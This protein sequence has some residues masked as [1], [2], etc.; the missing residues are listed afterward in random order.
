[1]PS[2]GMCCHMGVVRA[3]VS[4]ERAPSIFRVERIRK[5]GTTSPVN[6]PINRYWKL[7]DLPLGVLSDL[8]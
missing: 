2:S 4:E 3:D 7:Q 6:Y 1:M 8:F 5:R